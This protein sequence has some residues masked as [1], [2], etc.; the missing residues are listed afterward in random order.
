MRPRR[1]IIVGMTHFTEHH[2]TNEMLSKLKESDG[3][4]VEMGYDGMA[5]KIPLCVD[6]PPAPPAA[7]VAETTPG[8]PS[9]SPAAAPVGAD[10]SAASA[11][12]A[13]AAPT[14]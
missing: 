7:A 13:A 5:F 10:T 2:S 6:I 12:V 8:A 9:E 1:T 3:L 4:D 14:S 11:P